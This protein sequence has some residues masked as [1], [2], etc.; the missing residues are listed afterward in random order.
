[1][2]RTTA[3]V[4]LHV[5]RVVNRRMNRSEALTRLDRLE[6]LHL[7]FAS[8]QRLMR[9]L[10]SI[11]HAQSLFV[12]ARKADFADRR[13][14]GFQFVGHDGCRNETLASKQASEKL[15]CRSLVTSSLDEDVKDLAFAVDGAPH[16]HLPTTN[17]DHHFIEMPSMVRPRSKALSK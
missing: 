3:Q 10:S 14:I 16:I 1:M 12:R 9:V 5:E 7:P 15:Q 8:P 11:V 2:R 17:R 4:P 13:P 6:A